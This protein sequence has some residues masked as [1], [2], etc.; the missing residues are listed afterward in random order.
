MDRTWVEMGHGND[1]LD[2]NVGEA[3]L[4]QTRPARLEWW[5]RSRSTSTASELIG[6]EAKARRQHL[7]RR[8]LDR[9]PGMCVQEHSVKIGHP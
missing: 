6:K 9:F 7:L 2:G 4:F 3:K 1:E 5:A 8:L